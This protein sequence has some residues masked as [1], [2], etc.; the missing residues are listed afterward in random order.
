VDELLT[1]LG[2]QR[3]VLEIL[4]FRLL[5]ARGLLATGEVRFLHLAAQD[6]EAACE[7]VREVEL[8]RALL[9]LPDGAT[10]SQ[11]ADVASAP[12]NDILHDHLL[13]LS[14]LGAE[15]GAASEAVNELSAIGLTRTRDGEL[16]A[17]VP[18][19]RRSSAPMDDLDR[20]IVAAGYES[21]LNAS[22]RLMLPSLVAFL[23]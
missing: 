8:R 18:G 12:L 6:I 19:R 9:P 14:R 22:A 17:T 16:V 1:V 5:E 10:L 20:E 13:D 2:R 21:V 23:G 3:H 4:L 11:L 7:S 15:V